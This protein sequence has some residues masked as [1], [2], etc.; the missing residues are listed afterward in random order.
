MVNSPETGA[1]IDAKGQSSSAA[2]A[3]RKRCQ[4]CATVGSRWHSWARLL[5]AESDRLATR[6]CLSSGMSR[7]RRERAAMQDSSSSDDEYDET[8]PLT[9]GGGAAVKFG[10]EAAAVPGCLRPLLRLDLEAARAL[11][12]WTVDS[13]VL[14]VCAEVVSLS[15]D[16]A[17]WFGV[18]GAGSVLFLLRLLG[19]LRSTMSCQEELCFELFG[20]AAVCCVVE[21][22]FKFVFQRERPPWTPPQKQWVVPAEWL[23]FPSGH[24]LRA[25][26][27]PQSCTQLAQDAC[28][29][30]QQRHDRTH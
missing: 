13:T 24:S 1:R 15:G 16:E 3:S 26:C 10:W 18:G 2:S 25:F 17:I 5:R 20:G 22:L 19:L 28:Y 29:R 14:A 11:R 27:K 30:M 8:T 7:R 12:Q 4:I 21:Q 9:G 23:S 6:S